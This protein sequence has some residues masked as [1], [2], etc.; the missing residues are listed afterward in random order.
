MA[1]AAEEIVIVGDGMCGKTSVIKVF[2]NNS[3]PVKYIPTVF[4][5]HTCKM[6]FEGKDVRLS[7]W[8]TAVQED[9]EI[10][11]PLLYRQATVFIVMYSVD[12]PES[13]QNVHEKWVPEVRNYCPN[14]PIILVATK[15]D[16]RHKSSLIAQLSE[17]NLVP[18][19]TSDGR[20]MARK[21]NA[22]A[23]KEC[24]AVTNKGVRDVFKTAVRAAQIRKK[25]NPLK[26]LTSSFVKILQKNNEKTVKGMISAQQTLL[27][28]F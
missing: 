15:T 9:F 5:N 17:E 8:D 25:N 10:F 11:R 2:L 12:R 19:S 22:F 18:V 28:E 20:Q 6:K 7:M 3:F 4:E 24:S 1:F 21:I 14:A 26:W 27:V 16:L 13:L 23:F